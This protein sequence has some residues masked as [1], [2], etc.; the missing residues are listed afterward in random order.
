MPVILYFRH[1]EMELIK[2]QKLI[3]VQKNVN[4]NKIPIKGSSLSEITFVFISA[5]LLRA[6]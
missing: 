2:C 5:I 4:V 3:I 1:A 6:H